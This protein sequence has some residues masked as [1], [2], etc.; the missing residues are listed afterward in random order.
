M[1]RHG[2][3]RHYKQYVTNWATRLT[4]LAPVAERKKNHLI[5]MRCRSSELSDVSKMFSRYFLRCERTIK[6]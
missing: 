6:T 3:A 2:Y 1:L 4:N 5:V